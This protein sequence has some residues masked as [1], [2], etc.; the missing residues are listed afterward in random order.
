IANV[1]MET[2][3]S[4]QLGNLVNGDRAR[5]TSITE[6]TNNGMSLDASLRRELRRLA[7]ALIRL[8]ECLGAPH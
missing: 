1:Q 3:S 7:R 6:N 8:S 2:S 5:S 4:E